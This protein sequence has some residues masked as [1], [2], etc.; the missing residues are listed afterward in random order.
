VLPFAA[1]VVA[2]TFTMKAVGVFGKAGSAAYSAT[3]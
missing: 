3:Q 1:S 2:L